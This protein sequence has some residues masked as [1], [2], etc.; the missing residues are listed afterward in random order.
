M[1]QEDDN[2][3]FSAGD[4]VAPTSNQC[5]KKHHANMHVCKAYGVHSP[6]C[7][8]AQTQYVLQCADEPRPLYKEEPKEEVELGESDS[9][10]ASYSSGGS[11]SSSSGKAKAATVVVPPEETLREH[12]SPA[13][14]VCQ[15]EIDKSKLSCKKAVSQAYQEFKAA[16]DAVK[17]KSELAETRDGDED[18]VSKLYDEALENMDKDTASAFR[19]VTHKA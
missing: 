1:L 2:A 16:E 9:S 7:T 19:S 6:I 8:G 14:M 5:F 17:P 18:V 3:A 4:Q 11:Y 12:M 15:V 13:L 10:Y